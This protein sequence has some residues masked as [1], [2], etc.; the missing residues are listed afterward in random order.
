[1]MTNNGNATTTQKRDDAT[2]TQD[3]DDNIAQ[4]VS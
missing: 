4:G 2:M 3:N 1:M